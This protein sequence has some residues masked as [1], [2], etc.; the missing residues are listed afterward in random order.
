MIAFKEFPY[1]VENPQRVLE[2]MV[3]GSLMRWV[4]LLDE[5]PVDLDLFDDGLNRQVVAKLL[6]TVAD[7][8]DGSPIGLA[9]GESGVFVERVY[10][11][12]QNCLLSEVAY[13]F[14]HNLLKVQWAKR[15]LSQQLAGELD[16]SADVMDR[17]REAQSVLD[18]ITLKKQ[19]VEVVTPLSGHDDYV[20]ALG[21]GDR[22]MPSC[23]GGLNKLIGGWRDSALYVIGGRPG[24]GKSILLLQAAWELARAGRRVMFVSIEMPVVQLQ[25]RILAQTLGMNVS[26]IADNDLSMDFHSVDSSFV[27]SHYQAIK[28]AK[29]LLND[30]LLMLAPVGLK[31][32]EL[33]G[34][35]RQQKRLGDVDA[36][37]V[38][39]LQI[40]DSDTR[41]EMRSE[42]VG[43][44]AVQLK[45]IAKQ[46]DIPVVT[47]VQLNR[48][49][50][51]RGKDARPLLTDIGESD[52]IGNNAD[53][54]LLIHREVQEGDN[55]DGMGTDFYLAVVKNRHGRTGQVR[56]LAQDHL[57]RVVDAR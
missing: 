33:H 32:S 23:W 49:Y 15:L 26:L 34:Y 25:N 10:D 29:P 52:K 39:Y 30:N 56:L 31:P 1:P 41:Q 54:A 47:G 35:V 44:I 57:S 36:V 8:G 22:F 16:E 27:E 42:V 19:V 17:V 51:S 5:F 21:E 7:G 45:A 2:L 14:Y 28:D 11:C 24:T 13:K 53:V 50:S 6:L 48:D 20:L 43:Q 55:P 37:F 3:V 38:D 4:K 12:F 9:L 40:I 46:Y 18:R